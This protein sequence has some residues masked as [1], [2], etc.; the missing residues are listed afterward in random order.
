[1][2]LK[3][4]TYESRFDQLN[5]GQLLPERDFGT[6]TPESVLEGMIFRVAVICRADFRT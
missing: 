6:M 2:W 5:R 3:V 1:M 4:S